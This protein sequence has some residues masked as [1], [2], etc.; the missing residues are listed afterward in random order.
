MA[1]LKKYEYPDWLKKAYPDLYKK[2]N[3]CKTTKRACVELWY[4]VVKARAGYKSEVSG[5][6][7][8]QIGGNAILNAHHGLGR[9]GALLLDLSNGICIT[10]GE[11]FSAHSP[12][13]TTSEYMREKVEYEI[14]G[15]DKFIHPIKTI[16]DCELVK[17][18][19]SEEREKLL[20]KLFDLR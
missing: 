18:N 4:E 2:V 9:R 5:A 7:G 10:Q 17:L 15:R 6:E 3:K 13:M 14:V 8:K 1:K 16:E 12:N 19:L 11:H 20:Q